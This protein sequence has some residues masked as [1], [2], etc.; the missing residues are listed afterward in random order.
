[1]QTCFGKHDCENL[2][3]CDGCDME[4]HTYCMSPPL[5][6]IPQG[7]WFCFDCI[8]NDRTFTDEDE[9]DEDEDDDNENKSDDKEARFL[10][11][12]SDGSVDPTSEQIPVV[13]RPG[14]PKGSVGKKRAELLQT[15]YGGNQ[16]AMQAALKMRKKNHV[17]EK[18]KSKV[19]V[20]SDFDL[21]SAVQNNIS[22][23]VGIETAREI[24][25]RSA[26]RLLYQHELKN[27]TNFRQWAP[28][29]DL[30]DALDAFKQQRAELL[31]RLEGGNGHLSEN[32]NEIDMDLD[33]SPLKSNVL[34]DAA[35][36]NPNDDVSFDLSHD[37]IEGKIDDESFSMD[38]E[39][40]E[41]DD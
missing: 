26:R 27:L 32:R 10:S 22:E 39:D 40:E 30:K 34:T 37:D 19:S 4:W 24:A 14:R 15:F 23:P 12:S 8:A 35:L 36:D 1:M 3:L 9:D 18:R 41:A 31:K 11:N 16:S 29:H 38:F 7:N 21:P 13:R 25:A 28:I 2:I 6:E 20:S 17:V 33:F 5:T